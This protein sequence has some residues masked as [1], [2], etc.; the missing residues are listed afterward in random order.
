MRMTAYIPPLNSSGLSRDVSPLGRRMLRRS[1]EERRTLEE[2]IFSRSHGTLSSA[3]S[4]APLLVSPLSRLISRRLNYE[5]SL[6]S[7]ETKRCWA[8]TR[9]MK[10]YILLLHHGYLAYRCLKL[11]RKTVRKLRQ[12]TSDSSTVWE[13][14]N[15]SLRPSRSTSSSSPSERRLISDVRFLKDSEGFTDG[16][17]VSD[18]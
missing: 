11:Q 4:L 1:L 16:T 17:T 13:L 15:S 7:A 8:S 10:I 18:E 14:R 6:F 9:G 12:L 2:S 5:W 3:D